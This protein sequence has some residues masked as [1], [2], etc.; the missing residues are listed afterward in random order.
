MTNS[1]GQEPTTVKGIARISVILDCLTRHYPRQLPLAEIARETRIPKPTAHRLLGAMREEGFVTCDPV[2]GDYLLGYRMLDIGA[3]ALRQNFAMASRS[4]IQRL[5]TRTGDTAFCAVSEGNSFC[6]VMRISGDY[7]VRTLSLE[8]GDRWPLGVG[9]L[10]LAL[11]ASH[12][13]DF[14]D[15]YIHTQIASI[16]DYMDVTP[17]SLWE[18]VR[19]T[20][21]QGYAASANSIITGM[22]AMGVAVNFPNSTRPMGAVSV[23][24]ISNR[25]NG[26]RKS[27][28]I[29]MLETEKT[30]I[31]ANLTLDDPQESFAG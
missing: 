25:L 16:N 15:R 2:D 6:C 5:A 4:S 19:Q 10:G 28:V 22:S 27:Q 24:A 17:A 29:K 3:K 13:D 21:K 30:L 20:R 9:A 11:L 14:I 23:A 26:A 12:G 31:E 8:T 7:P 18:D 1:A